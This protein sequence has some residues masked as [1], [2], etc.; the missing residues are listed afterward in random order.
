[1]ADPKGFLKYNRKDNPMRPIMQRVKDF[2]AMELD[3]GDDDRR[4]QA[5]QGADL[6]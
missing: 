5:R 1:M 2:D 6:R 3:L 4:E